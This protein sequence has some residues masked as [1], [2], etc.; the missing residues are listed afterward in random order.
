MMLKNFIFY[1][2]N[3]SN[4]EN[5]FCLKFCFNIIKFKATKHSE[6]KF[7][8]CHLIRVKALIIWK[9][10]KKIEHAWLN[11]NDDWRRVEKLL[12]HHHETEKKCFSVE[13]L[14]EYNC[15]K[16]DQFFFSSVEMSVVVV[17]KKTMSTTTAKLLKKNEKRAQLKNMTI[18]KMFQLVILHQCDDQKCTNF[19]QYCWKNFVDQH[20]Y[21]FNADVL[22]F[23]FTILKKHQFDV[24]VKNSFHHIKQNFFAHA[25]RKKKKKIHL[26]KINISKCFKYNNLSF[27]IFHIFFFS[28]TSAKMFSANIIHQKFFALTELGAYF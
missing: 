17:N 19:D 26:M 24:D 18:E 12:K 5:T 25:M 28:R 27:F 3:F 2:I 7:F 4:V 20:H 21:K 10:I 16:N 6:I 9:F 13:M 8:V 1:K 22:N 23:W 14:Y 15:A 11:V